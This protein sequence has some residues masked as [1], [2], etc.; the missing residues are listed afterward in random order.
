MKIVM[1]SDTHGKSPAVPDGDILIHA[2]DLTMQGRP[3]EVYD[4]SRWLKTLPHKYKIV[5]AGNHDFLFEQYPAEAEN[6]LGEDVHYLNNSST[7]IQGLRIWGSP[8]TPWFCDWAFNVERGEDIR[9]YWAQ[10]P[11][12]THIV[13]THG[14]PRGILDQAAPHKNTEHLGCD[15][16][17]MRIKEIKPLIHVFGHIHGGYGC[18]RDSNGTEFYNA[19]ILNEA[20]QISNEPW[21]VSL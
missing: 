2:G 5:I 18:Y 3:E 21:V 6:M 8:V 19:S 16:L 12:N 10:I 17:L 7:L 1:I 14:P 9:A 4:A 11:E 20:Y 13:I 15:D